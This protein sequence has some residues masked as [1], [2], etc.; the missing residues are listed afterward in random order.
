MSTRPGKNPSFTL[1]SGAMALALAWLAPT[2]A[3][4]WIRPNPRRAPPPEP[5]EKPTRFD[6]RW[7]EPYFGSGPAA[8]AAERF[9][10]EDWRGAIPKLQEA[11]RTLPAGSAERLGARFLEGLARTELGEWAVARDL[12]EQL[13]QHYP[14][15]APYHAFQAA[16]CRLALGDAAGALTWV[17]KVPPGTVPEAEARLLKM[18]AL[19]ETRL[20]EPVE[21]EARLYLEKFASGPRRAE[22]M[23]RQAEAMENLNRDP[24]AIAALYRRIWAEAPLESWAR[25]AEDRLSAL[26]GS[27]AAAAPAGRKPSGGVAPADLRRFSAGDWLTR[28]MVFFE[29][30]QNERAES[31]FA[32]A[33]SEAAVTLPGASGADLR[34]QAEFHR[35]QSI[36]KQ[37]Q[38][39]RAAPVFL[40]AE[41]ACLASRNADLLTKSRY[42]GARC[43][44]NAGD[45]A[46]ALEKYALIER[47]SPRHSY[48]DDARLRAAEIHTDLGELDRAASLLSDLPE[49]H[50]GGDMMGEALWR[51]ALAAIQQQRWDE[52]HRWLDE[53]LRRVP[54]EE[55]W[56]AEGRALYWKARVFVKQGEK[57]QALAYLQRAV[58]EYPLSVYA[59]LA[60][61]RMRVEFPSQRANLVRELHNQLVA[62]PS[63]GIQFGARPVYG[64]EEFRRAVE[65]ARLGLGSEARRELSRIGFNPPATRDAARANP[66]V[67][68]EQEDVYLVTALLLDRGRSWSAAHAIP[69]YSL[70]GFRTGY[71]GGRQATLWRLAYP[72]AFPELVGPACKTNDV[73][74][75][76]QLAIM[77]E[78][79]SFNPRVESIANA[80]GLT[81]MLVKT[82]ARFSDRSVSRETLLD[83]ARNVELGSR[84][85]GFLL[86]RYNGMP[87]LAI[88]SY[89]GGEGAVDRW[90]RERGDLEL[91]EFLETIPY[92]ETRNYTKRVLSSFLAYSW[93]YEPRKPVPELSFKLKPARPERVGRPPA[94]TSKSRPK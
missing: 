18:Q 41:A 13:H 25:R 81:Q 52:A 42:Q 48:A 10:R 39:A 74:E 59:L 1:V 63:G 73:P 57:K 61:E 92:D 33:L 38:R 29:R 60:L 44:A 50:P 32:A 35:G 54:R 45:K 30:N 68:D 24:A 72:R 15:L 46:T 3:A 28:G 27:V 75:A 14:V 16:R 5:A 83:P 69:R 36:F 70:P 91:D 23:F 89:N 67:G 51:L 76:L 37:R 12:F 62:T 90:L 66:P 77:R 40:L 56:Y 87:P 53:N 43:L 2:E 79:S 65:L 20:W 78:E 11:A 22:A 26:A 55:I 47:D 4:A 7:L 49:R 17:D 86:K 6:R 31:A 93:L 85:L 19:A 71:P 64:S 9:R 80:L 21:T 82:A 88:A 94:R 58:R 34:C 8:A 84:F